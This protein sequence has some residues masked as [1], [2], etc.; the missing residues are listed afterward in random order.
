MNK[1]HINS[2]SLKY[3]FILFFFFFLSNN[4]FSIQYEMD[5]KDINHKNN[6]E[7]EFYVT[8]RGVEAPFNLTSFQVALRLNNLEQLGED[9]VFSYIDNSSEL[10]NIPAYGIHASN[11]DGLPEVTFAALPGNDVIA[12]SPKTVG[13][14]LISSSSTDLSEVNLEWDFEGI[15]S[16]IILGDNFSNITSPENHFTQGDYTGLDN[17]VEIP[18]VFSLSQNYPNPFNPSTT[19]SFNLP[20]ESEVNLSI[21]N[22]LGQLV[23]TL[24]NNRLQAGSYSVKFES[25]SGSIASGVYIYRISAKS[26]NNEFSETRKMILT[27]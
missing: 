7:I 5:V 10:T 2:F 24:V 1:L 6:N 22:I 25:S 16:T 19:I 26:G 3:T 27:K 12:E 23:K 20:S 11:Y 8:I 9:V 15:N 13:K 21:Y 18:S 4:A 14:F 17:S